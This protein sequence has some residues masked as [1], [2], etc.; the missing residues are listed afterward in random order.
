MILMTVE[1]DQSHRCELEPKSNRLRRDDQSGKFQTNL[2][3]CQ[4]DILTNN[5]WVNFISKPKWHLCHIPLTHCCPCTFIIQGIYYYFII[6]DSWTHSGHR[7]LSP[8]TGL[9]SRS[10]GIQALASDVTTPFKGHYHLLSLPYGPV[11]TCS[12]RLLWPSTCG[13]GRYLGLLRDD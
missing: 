13:A 3:I 1:R 11:G 12:T 2:F 8:A 7:V 6:Q 10:S 5:I 9:D 4:Q